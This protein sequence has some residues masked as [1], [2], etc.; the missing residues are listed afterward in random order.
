MFF[1]Y[2]LIYEKK[3][4]LEDVP[5]ENKVHELYLN[6]EETDNSQLSEMLQYFRTADP[7][8]QRFGA[9]SDTV[10]EQKG[11]KEEVTDM[12]KAVEDYAREREALAKTN[13]AIEVVNNL[14]AEGFSLEKSLKLAGIDEETYRQYSDK[15]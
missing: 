3:S 11:V 9:L 7:T 6:A 4:L 5:W 15:K 2:V 8:D 13:K 10:R 12:C 1:V 14:L